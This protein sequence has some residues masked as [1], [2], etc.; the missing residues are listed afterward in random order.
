MPWA[1]FAS[2][3][4]E[5]LRL[6]RAAC[7]T[8]DGTSMSSVVLSSLMSVHRLQESTAMAR[9]KKTATKPAI[10]VQRG[11]GLD[12]RDRRDSSVGKKTPIRTCRAARTGSSVPGVSFAEMRAFLPTGACVQQS[13]G[14][15][16]QAWMQAR[17]A[18]GSS[19]TVDLAS[20]SGRTGFK[21][22]AAT[23]APQGDSAEQEK[24]RHAADRADTEGCQGGPG[25][26]EFQCM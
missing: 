2:G 1:R 17:A 13:K 6:G 14:E 24:V 15:W 12:V 20:H 8:S 19:A 9:T 22:S 10:G 25:A 4:C 18:Q 3:R 26:P 11:S 5:W 23:K 7:S 21:Q 16:M